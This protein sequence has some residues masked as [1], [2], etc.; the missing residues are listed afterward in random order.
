ML[1]TERLKSWLASP[2]PLA[3]LLVLTAFIHLP[4]L[5]SGG[6]YWDGWIWISLVRSRNLSVLWSALTQAG[7]T[8]TF[9]FYAWLT[10]FEDPVFASR[11]LVF[12]STLVSVGSLH[13]ILRVHR[14]GSRES[15]FWGC[16]LAACL[17][18]YWVTIESCVAPYS[19]TLA[20][21]FTAIFLKYG[22]MRESQ[23]FS[24]LL[25][26][27]LALLF[28]YVS[29][30]MPSLILVYPFALIS[31]Y[32]LDPKRH[33]LPFFSPNRIYN[34][35]LRHLA[36]LS[37]PFLSRLFA[38]KPTGFYANYNSVDL[39]PVH[40][41]EAF[42]IAFRDLLR[43][44]KHPLILSFKFPVSF[45]LTGLLVLI[46]LYVAKAL[47][48]QNETEQRD[49]SE[50]APALSTRWKWT[51]IAAVFI[52]TQLPYH[53]VGK[54]ASPAN[55]D[56]RHGLLLSFGLGV[57]FALAFAAKK[58]PLW[59]KRSR[60]AA[61][62][63]LSLFSMQ[64]FWN[65][66]RWD[67]DWYKETSFIFALAHAP[68]NLLNHTDL[69]FTD[70]TNQP[71]AMNREYRDYELAVML[72]NATGHSCRLPWMA[73]EKPNEQLVDSP[74]SRAF[75]LVSEY[76][77]GKENEPVLLQNVESARLKEFADLPVLGCP[78]EKSSGKVAF[79]RNPDSEF[80]HSSYLKLKALELFDRERF[81]TVLSNAL[82]V[83]EIK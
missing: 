31:F 3:L 70:E 79:A 21:F 80:A 43:F 28:F 14:L 2:N 66:A 83:T 34:W 62:I 60:L 15:R 72:L 75:Y 5:L 8:N 58:A 41:F 11:V 73:S 82:L 52:G 19:I 24:N 30:G 77:L 25:L 46:L 18:T 81:R 6:V 51:L 57:I 36:F 4:L 67:L 59:Q 9:L 54:I 10:R 7:L 68:S 38:L 20:L 53:L 78:S 23:G 35:S 71:N 76:T 33:G 13:E 39:D 50:S 56:S 69:E 42:T 48:S 65:Y 27:G 16:V 29:F 22:S 37:L 17:P 63:A 49:R 64:S 45:I 40:Y 74:E 32:A 26:N 12:V 55:W 47:R 44:L 1:K 61:V